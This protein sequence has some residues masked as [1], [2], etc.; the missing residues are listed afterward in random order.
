[1]KEERQRLSHPG[2]TAWPAERLSRPREAVKLTE[3]ADSLLLLFELSC[4]QLKAVGTWEIFV[5]QCVA[6]Q[7]V[8][9]AF[10]LIQKT[11]GEIMELCEVRRRA[12]KLRRP[13]LLRFCFL[14]RVSA[15]FTA[16]HEVVAWKMKDFTCTK[17]GP[18]YVIA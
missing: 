12:T 18:L 1:M 4:E 15:L 5:K 8:F 10:M 7:V 16:D 17:E 14:N 13:V 3:D 2:N 6:L 9:G 11:W